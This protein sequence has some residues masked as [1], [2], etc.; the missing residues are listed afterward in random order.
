MHPQHYWGEV[1]TNCAIV[2]E[3]PFD[4]R[5]TMTLLTSADPT[6]NKPVV[7]D[8]QEASNT[9]WDY[10]TFVINCVKSGY[11]KPGDFLVSQCH[12]FIPII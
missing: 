3:E 11:L 8:L 2:N 4:T 12:L 5:Y 10:L 9:Q 1:G 6:T 7:V